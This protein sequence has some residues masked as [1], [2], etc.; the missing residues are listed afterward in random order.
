MAPRTSSPIHSPL[1]YNDFAPYV[2]NW[3]EDEN[4]LQGFN[5]R[6]EI[7]PDI[8]LKIC[9]DENVTFTQVCQI[10][11]L[12]PNQALHS[13][14]NGCNTLHWACHR[15]SLPI[16]RLLLENVPK[17]AEAKDNYGETPLQWACRYGSHELV[18]YFL[19]KAP[20]TAIIADNDGRLPIHW[21][22]RWDKFDT[23]KLLNEAAPKTQKNED[24]NGWTPLLLATRWASSD[25]VSLLTGSWSSSIDKDSRTSENDDFLLLDASSKMLERFTEKLGIMHL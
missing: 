24:K 13:D 8:L 5:L 20:Q 15:N 3:N 1:K 17:A 16:V 18:K 19:E 12:F 22:C 25:I 14:S 21:A 11:H 7:K 9:K 4:Y 2:S 10:F 23:V 6:K